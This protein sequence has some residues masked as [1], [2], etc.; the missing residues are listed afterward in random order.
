[1]KIR[2]L[3]SRIQSIVDDIDLWQNELRVE[4][5]NEGKARS[6]DIKFGTYAIRVSMPLAGDFA[7]FTQYAA[8][9]EQPESDTVYDITITDSNGSDPSSGEFRLSD[10]DTKIRSYIEDVS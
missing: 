5:S 10:L 8:E 2:E 4:I 9:I 6:V 1:M 3:E 7:A